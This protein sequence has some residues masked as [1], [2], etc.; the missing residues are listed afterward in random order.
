VYSCR[1]GIAKPD[2]SIFEQALEIIGAT[3][4]QTLF[5][6]DQPANTRAAARLGLRTLTFSS[7]ADLNRALND[8]L[9]VSC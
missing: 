4:A 9:P 6:D 3:P 7:N 2:A 1:L 8:H 5:I